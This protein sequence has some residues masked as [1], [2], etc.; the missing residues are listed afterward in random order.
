MGKRLYIC[1]TFYQVYVTF[2]KEFALGNTD[3]KEADIILSCTATDYDGLENRLEDCD[4]FDQVFTMDERIDNDQ[5]LVRLKKDR[6]N[7]VLNLLQRIVYTYKR[8]KVLEPNLPKNLNLKSYGDIYVFCDSDPIGFYLSRKH[9]YY[10]A[11]EDGLNCLEI[12]DAAHYDNRGHFGIKKWMSSHNLIHIQNG[13]SKYCLDMEINDD[14]KLKFQCPKY[15]VVPRKPLEE[16]LTSQEKNIL[17]DAMIPDAGAIR[18]S[19]N[20]AGGDCVLF[21]TMPHPKPEEIR[22]QICD[23]IIRDYCQSCHVVIKPHPRETLDYA[24]YRPDCT[25]LKGRFP[26]EILNYLVGVHFRRAITIVS[27]SLDG[28]NFCDEKI[29]L[30]EDFWD[31]YEDPELHKYNQTLERAQSENKK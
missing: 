2:L 18:E 10:H 24:A 6:G 12:F 19:I 27:T 30:G 17:V 7:I 23:D 31:A 9:I 21:L 22:K 13:Y 11:L 3:K 1:H 29:R 25:V 20:K 15:V 26:I 4:V 14:S 5:R 28:I 16:R 8:A